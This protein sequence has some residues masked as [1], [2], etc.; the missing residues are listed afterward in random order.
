[1]VWHEAEQPG[2]ALTDSYYTCKTSTGWL[3]KA[4][5]NDVSA[6][7]MTHRT[8]N[9][10]CTARGR[11]PMVSLS[12][13]NYAISTNPNSADFLPLNFLGD[14]TGSWWHNA[15]GIEWITAYTGQEIIQSGYYGDVYLGLSYY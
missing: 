15:S 14:Y 10:S 4:H 12:W 13:G 9:I 8:T 6:R 11:L 2:Q 5:V 3:A 1:M 7:A